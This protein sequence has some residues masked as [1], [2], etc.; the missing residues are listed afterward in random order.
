M[1]IEYRFVTTQA[2]QFASRVGELSKEGFTVNQFVQS[3]NHFHI[4][5]EKWNYP[6][7]ED[8]SIETEAEELWSEVSILKRQLKVLT[9]LM[10]PGAEE[11]EEPAGE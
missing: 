11:E 9:E 1:D 7:K 3:G 2:G 8:S 4:L 10:V 6:E 5:L